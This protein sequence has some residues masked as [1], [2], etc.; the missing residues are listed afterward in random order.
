MKLFG[1]LLSPYVTRVVLAI[2]FKGLDI[3]LVP[4][5]GAG[6]KSP[7]YLAINPYGKMPALDAGDAS[8]IESEVICEFLDERFPEKKILPGND[9]ARAR[10]RIISRAIDLYVLP[11]LLGLLGQMN[12][13]NRDAALVAE[14]R[15][16]LRR[17]LDGLE[18]FIEA[19]PWCMGADF[20][21]ADCAVV[22]ACF[23]LQKFLPAFGVMDVFENHPKLGTV[24][25]HANSDPMGAKLIAEMTGAL[26]DFMRRRAANS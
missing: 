10:A 14:K 17:G 19:A 1:A 5:P 11:A 13:I 12:P 22:P 2:R 7:E 4:P 8:I 16:E 24:W 25:E 9:V 6:L 21:L 18:T 20:T 15:A 3:P 23:F 26:D